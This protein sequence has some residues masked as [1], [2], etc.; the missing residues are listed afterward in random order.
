MRRYRSNN[1]KLA[2]NACK[3]E[4]NTLELSNSKEIKQGDLDKSTWMIPVHESKLGKRHG[5]M[6]NK[7]NQNISNLDEG[8]C[9]SEDKCIDSARLNQLK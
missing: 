9:D 4:D 1:Y 2:S 6:D 5:L 7:D 8:S 3:P